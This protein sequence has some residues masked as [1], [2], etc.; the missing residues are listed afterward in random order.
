M[1]TTPIHY[2]IFEWYLIGSF[3]DFPYLEPVII[4]SPAE[5][6]VGPNRSQIKFGP[7]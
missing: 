3:P 5:M 4:M 2:V 7:L 1:S 6:T